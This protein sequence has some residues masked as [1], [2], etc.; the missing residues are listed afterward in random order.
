VTTELT[1][2]KV[3]QVVLLNLWSEFRTKFV[4]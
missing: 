1:G 2:P 4:D 3:R